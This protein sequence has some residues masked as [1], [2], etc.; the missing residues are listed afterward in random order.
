MSDQAYTTVQKICIVSELYQL[1]LIVH[2]QT[3]HFYCFMRLDII[4]KINAELGRSPRSLCRDRSLSTMQIFGRYNLPN[5]VESRLNAGVGRKCRSSLDRLEC[6][7]ASLTHKKRTKP[8]CLY[9]TLFV[10]CPFFCSFR[11]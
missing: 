9:V 10:L 6:L 5:G 4:I 7:V 11:Y 2:N 3:S 1:I 8:W